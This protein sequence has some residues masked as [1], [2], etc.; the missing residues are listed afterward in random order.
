MV[1][2]KKMYEDLKKR[3]EE[4]SIPIKADYLCPKCNSELLESHSELYC[5]NEECDFD[6]T[7]GD[8]INI[9]AEYRGLERIE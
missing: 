5:S 1:S 7:F 9:Y 4:D 2:Y 3:M 8:L 6:K